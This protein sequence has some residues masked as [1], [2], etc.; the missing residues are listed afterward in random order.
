[1]TRYFKMIAFCG[2]YAILFAAPSPSKAGNYTASENASWTVVT[3]DFSSGVSRLGQMIFAYFGDSVNNNAPFY[4]NSGELEVDAFR[5]YQT[6]V[7]GGVPGNPTAFEATVSTADTLGKEAWLTFP[8]GTVS[9]NGA[10]QVGGTALLNI[11][12]T[13][14]GSYQNSN[15]GSVDCA[16]NATYYAHLPGNMSIEVVVSQSGTGHGHH[17]GEL[18]AT[19]PTDAL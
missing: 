3:D 11:G 17:W 15:T 13:L 8:G 12:S 2:L 19:F 9:Y 10:A 6:W 7:G 5:R 14:S 18:K 4:T 1:M 16:L